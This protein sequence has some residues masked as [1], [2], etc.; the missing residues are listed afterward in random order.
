MS[1]LYRGYRNSRTQVVD[2]S[3]V[4]VM[5][6]GDFRPLDPR[7]DLIKHSS[8]FEWGFYGSG[9]AQLALAILADA[10]G[11]DGYAFD[12]YMVFEHDVVAKMKGDLYITD[13]TVKLWMSRVSKDQLAVG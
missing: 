1:K 4:S 11:D 12:N 3:T 10:T 5:E 9:P 7:F 6:D 13:T 8:D 2:Q